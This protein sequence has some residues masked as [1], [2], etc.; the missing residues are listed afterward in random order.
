MIELFK[1]TNIDYENNGD[2]TL[3]PSNCTLNVELNGTWELTLEYPYDASEEFNAITEE[4]VIA[5]PTPE[6]KRQLFRV[7]DKD[8]NDSYITVLARP[9][10]LD[11]ANDTIILNKHIVDRTGQQALPLITEGT[12]YKA[13]SDILDINTAYY[14]R[15]NIVEAIA[16]DDENSFINRWKGEILYDNYKIIVN[17]K[18]GKDRGVSAEF[19]KNLKSIQEKVNMDGVVTRIIPIAYNGHMLDGDAP[20]VDSPLINHYPTIKIRTINYDDV[21]LT[22]DAG[23]DEE[24]YDTLEE[25]RE[26]LVER[27]NAE[28]EAGIDKPTCSYIVNM[29]DLSKTVEYEEY[30]ILEE[31]HLGDTI[32]CKNKNLDIETNARVV[33]YSF[34]CVNERFEDIILGEFEKNYLT[35]ISSQIQSML[36]NFDSNNRVKGESIAGVINLMEAKLKATRDIAKKQNER[37]ILFEDLDPDSPTYGA[38]AL[39]TTGFCIASKQD[40]TGDWVWS[41]IGT[42]QGFLADCIIAGVLYSKNYTEGKQGVKIDLNEGLI[43]AF[44]LAWTAKNSSMDSDGSLAVKNILVDNGKFKITKDGKMSWEATNSSMT[45]DGAMKCKSIEITGGKIEIETDNKELSI[46][47]LTCGNSKI[48]ISPN[49]INIE[50]GS[51][52]VD[53]TSGT[54]SFYNSTNKMLGSLSE[55][56]MLIYDENSK[57]RTRIS[58]NAIL[59]SDGTNSATLNYEKLNYLLNL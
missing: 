7:Y 35:D 33:G 30:K 39:G 44:K 31:V 11:A 14:V 49:G 5:V 55:N 27:A 19:G 58:K 22:E 6:S 13:E 15:K 34:D 18:L 9:I 28:F 53:I 21:K 4:A 20:W 47:K 25:L 24:G 41:T 59:L 3:H 10:F 32:R 1:K 42:G 40:S 48:Q 38:M 8:K 52:S 26:A 51:Y 43:N 2:Y 23:E 17:K 54:I 29:I 45:E 57:A 46:I 37:A 12:I 56:S 16:S 36:Q 50:D